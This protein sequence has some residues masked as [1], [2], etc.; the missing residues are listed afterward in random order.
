MTRLTQ[1]EYDYCSNCSAKYDCEHFKDKTFPVCFDKAMHEKLKRYEDLIEQGRIIELPCKVGDT[2]YC[3]A[4]PC[5]GCECYNDVMCE[6]FIE[7]C[8]NC[9]SWEIIECKF[10][11]DLYDEFGK[12]VF[13]TREEAEQAL[14]ERS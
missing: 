2:V 7:R 8:R 4:T 11:M 1:K 13:L 9:T 6:D 5:G 3:L 14:E 12:T 10:S